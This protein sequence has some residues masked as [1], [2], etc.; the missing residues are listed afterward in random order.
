M[1]YNN[2]NQK[3][4]I[5]SAAKNIAIE[6]G[7]TKINIRSVA[8]NSGIAIGTVYNLSLIHI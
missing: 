4:T 3:E 6:Q 1:P 7:I 5:L 2:K 8:Q